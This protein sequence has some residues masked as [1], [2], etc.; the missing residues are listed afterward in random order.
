M[1]RLVDDSEVRAAEA[2]AACDK[3]SRAAERNAADQSFEASDD[4]GRWTMLQM[5]LREQS[6]KPVPAKWVEWLLIYV[7]PPSSG[8]GV[9]VP[10]P[11][12]KRSG[13]QAFRRDPRDA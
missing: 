11:P 9:L 6:G 8:P 1:E 7:R 4:M 2:R 3:M 10:T 5:H 13:W 12:G